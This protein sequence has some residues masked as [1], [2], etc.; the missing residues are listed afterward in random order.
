M[1]SKGDDKMTVIFRV[2]NST[3]HKA[4]LHWINGCKSINDAYVE[5]TNR[6]ELTASHVVAVKTVYDDKGDVKYE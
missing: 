5:L 3:T 2:I 4:S 1:C 6:K